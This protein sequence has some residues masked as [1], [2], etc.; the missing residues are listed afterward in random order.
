M[1]GHEILQE[2]RNCLLKEGKTEGTEKWCNRA[3]F[4]HA[5]A[6]VGT[7]KWSMLYMVGKAEI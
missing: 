3:F 6:G 2:Q 5:K 4:T 7:K 1:D